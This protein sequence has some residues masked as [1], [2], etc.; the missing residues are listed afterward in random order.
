M[1]RKILL[2]RVLPIC[3]AL[4]VLTGVLIILFS[5][6]NDDPGNVPSQKSAIASFPALVSG[7]ASKFKPESKIKSDGL[8]YP[9]STIK[10][11]P[12]VTEAPEEEDLL[13]VVGD[14]ETLLKL[15][16]ERGALYDGS[17]PSYYYNGRGYYIEED[18][19]FP[20]IAAPM[21]SVAASASSPSMAPP[22]LADAGGNGVY[23]QTNEQVAGV[24][25]GDIVKTD[26]QYIYA[27]SPYGNSL[28]IIRAD[29]SDMEVVSTITFNNKDN[30]YDAEFYLVGGDRLVVVG[31]ENIPVSMLPMPYEDAAIQSTSDMIVDY[32]GWYSRS[33]TVL[34]IYDITDRTAP[35][36]LRHISMDGWNVSTRVIGDIVYI[37]TNK[38]VWGIAYDEADSPSILPYCLDTQV[39]DAYEPLAYDRIYY[40][41]D[42]DDC[43][44]ILIGT[45]DVYGDDPFEPV[46]YLGAGSDLYMSQ[47]AMYIT[48]LRYAE[49]VLDPGDQINIWR[50]WHEVTDILRFSIDGTDVRYTGT[51]TVEGS[52][53]NQYSMDEYNGYFRIA[54]TERSVGTYVTVL[55]AADMKTVGRTEPLAPG[56]YM[57]S[58]RFMGDIGYVV[59]FQNTDPLFT[60]DLS[61]PYNPTMLG[62]LNIP[63][64]SQYLHPLDDGLMLGIGRDTQ[65]IFTRDANGKETI[66]GFRDVGMKISL[67]DVSDPYDPKEI[68]KL[69]LGEGWA[70]VSDNPR[71]LMC[72]RSR[73]LYGFVM[74]NWS[75]SGPNALILSVD[76]GRLSV[77]AKL[78]SEQYFYMYNSRLCFIDNTLYL[79]YETGIEA[80][81]Y[82]SFARLGGITF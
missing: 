51:G 16:L 81:D 29:G 5:N 82:T 39:E 41:P 49:T 3:L 8:S 18:A 46:A 27:M 76:G 45:V 73:G 14:R 48:K 42:T 56:E 12:I 62:E 75:N 72:D 63:G 52:P 64:F 23:S 11:V 4:A 57:R 74:D 24:S 61:D 33:F 60:I 47:N 25:E 78:S 31:T 50:E 40:I 32:Y 6:R 21:P 10:A 68:D 44:Y 34:L 71:A 55:S 70:E 65:E 79:T 54:T 77:A 53:I 1:K 35:E 37:V 43:S 69:P 67:F 7:I 28:R 30:L 59:T 19:I 2:R 58:M 17:A 80:Y 38:N 66:V 36:E 13:P 20:D 15:L 9:V 26:G 22:D